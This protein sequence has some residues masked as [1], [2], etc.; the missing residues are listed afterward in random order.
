MST[1]IFSKKVA[2]LMDSFER[3]FR[4][5]TAGNAIPATAT[6][7]ATPALVV[8]AAPALPIFPPA[9]SLNNIKSSTDPATHVV[10]LQELSE[11]LSI[12]TEGT[13]TGSF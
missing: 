1:R 13:L 6:T 11:M 12:S 2:R 8:P 10:I 5:G 4:M 9:H 3:P 7:S